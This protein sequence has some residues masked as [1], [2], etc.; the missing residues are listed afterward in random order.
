MQS[1]TNQGVDTIDVLTQNVDQKLSTLDN[2]NDKLNKFETTMNTF[3]K[4]V[5]EITKR[6][7][8]FEKGMNEKYE[9]SK[10]ERD[11]LTTSVSKL[12]TEHYDFT[13]DVGHL[14]RDFDQ[15][16]ERHLDLQ[17]RSMR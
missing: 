5:D 11:N 1:T 14:Q 13:Q 8:D 4:T 15:L 17:T 9:S 6:M 3:V 16:F 2:L 12:Q 10:K 7:N